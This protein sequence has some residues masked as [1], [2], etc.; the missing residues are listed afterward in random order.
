MWKVLAPKS[1]MLSLCLFISIAASAQLP[2]DDALK[3][4]ATYRF[5]ESREPL[6]V[7]NDHVRRADN[8]GNAEEQKV[9][10]A[11]LLDVL[12][13][14][15]STDGVDF[16]CRQLS[17]IGSDAAVPVLAPML[18]KDEQSADWARYALEGI[19]GDAAEQALIA[20]A[21]K[22]SGRS[23]IGVINS[24][25]TRRC[26]AA[27]PALT[28]MIRD[29][30]ESVA[31]AAIF[32]L[33][34][35]GGDEA[36]RALAAARGVAPDSLTSTVADAYL[37]CADGFARDGQKDRALAIFSEMT[38]DS[39]TVPI[40]IAA[41][42][43]MVKVQGDA[44]IPTVITAFK[45]S[46]L[47]VHTV[48][49]GLARRLSGDAI[50]TAISQELS[51]FPP[52]S[53]ILSLQILKERGA[54]D[55]RDAVTALTASADP[56]VRLAAIQAL[57]TVG[58]ASSIPFLIET[59]V[60]GEGDDKRA[61]S[62]SLDLLRGNDVDNALANLLNTEDP[63]TRGEIVRS[64]GARAAA[65]AKGTLLTV[66]A[67]D[68][69]DAVKAKA[70]DALSTIAGPGDL[71][72]LLDLLVSAN[73]TAVQQ[74]AESTVVA[75]SQKMAE[76]NERAIAVL[77][78]LADVRGK[79]EVRASLV[80]VLGRIGDPSALPALRRV[81]Q[82][83]RNEKVQDAAVRALC[84]WPTAETLDDLQK[85]AANS[86]TDSHRSLA[87]RGLIRQLRLPSDRPAQT[88]LKLYEE[89]LNMAKSVDDKRLVLSGLGEVKDE[90]ALKLVEPLLN[91]EDLKAEA[92]QAME[93]IKKNIGQ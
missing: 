93:T 27:V 76:Q 47:K 33:G 43:G 40:R 50:V 82:N 87:F 23:K 18:T 69:D 72:A 17:I 4:V 37:M 41:I 51:N 91:N 39:Q 90:G 20:A 55:A 79:P 3:Y 54:S 48:A 14:G 70:Y 65:D 68:P 56:A 26:R 71:P 83:A 92:A 29:D 80:S 86:P 85:I 31:R 67:K 46:H 52:D 10:E 59:A 88:T 16:L 35:I 38:S 62:E 49:A 77:K 1:A 66:A 8:S 74:Q 13:A 24:L 57:S 19:P 22:N 53:Q 34:Q 21:Q 45:D 9:I 61:A 64:L 44:A 89:A 6:S 63:A 78:A 25:G 42:E 12:K 2:L 58:N 11:K 73:G 30:D 75:V 15:P 28:P 84:D 60:K 81:A 32:A 36:A 7:V 5:G